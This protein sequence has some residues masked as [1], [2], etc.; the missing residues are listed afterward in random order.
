LKKR[1]GNKLLMNDLKLKEQMISNPQCTMY[2]KHTS[3]P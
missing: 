3:P 2:I 1:Q